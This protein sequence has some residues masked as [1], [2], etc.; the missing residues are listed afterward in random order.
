M[1]RQ[2]FRDPLLQT[3][4]ESRATVI[5]DQTTLRNCIVSDCNTARSD[6]S[7]ARRAGTL[8]IFRGAI[9]AAVRHPQE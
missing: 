5:V 3:A 7:K 9:H 4:N 8:D 1:S 6:G 2:S